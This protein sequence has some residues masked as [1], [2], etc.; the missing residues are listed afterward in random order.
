MGKGKITR[1]NKGSDNGKAKHKR[2]KGDSP[3]DVLFSGF[4]I[5][6]IVQG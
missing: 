2:N 5:T 1:S 3:C 6:L 4:G